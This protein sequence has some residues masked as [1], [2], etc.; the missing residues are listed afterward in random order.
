MR[1]RLAT[2]NL[3]SGRSIDDGLIAPAQLSAAARLL[4]A[5][6]LAIQEADRYQPRSGLQDQAAVMASVM[7]AATGTVSWRFG[8][9][10]HG[11]PGE[12]GWM[13]G[14]GALPVGDDSP[15]FGVALLSR[16]PVESWHE[17]RLTPGRG[18]MPMLI[19]SRP[20]RMLWLRDEPRAAIAAVIAEPRMTIA[21]THLSFMPARTA[22]QLAQV[23]R[24]LAELPAPRV[25]MGDLNLVPV[26]GRRLM[27]GWQGLAQR[28]TFPS[29]RPRLQLDH[30][31]AQGLSPDLAVASQAQRMPVSDHCALS[32][33]L[34][35]D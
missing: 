12:P 25:L 15:G 24:W 30:I 31:L 29:P 21:C 35:L 22:R 16:L 6:V 33:E 10:V 5:D 7:E 26:F 14:R 18:R 11:T 20:P 27:P 9:T 23:R 1:L 13:P 4:D 17:L 2:F 3:M 32:V 8:E 28:P 34:R 19:P